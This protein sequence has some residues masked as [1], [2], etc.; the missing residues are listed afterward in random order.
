METHIQDLENYL[1]E[2]FNDLDDEGKVKARDL[3]DKNK[4]AVNEAIGKI[5][6]VVPNVK[7]DNELD[8]FLY[9]VKA[10]SN[11]A[12]KYTK[13]MIS[14]L[15]KNGNNQYSAQY[16][17]DSKNLLHSTEDLGMLYTLK[18]YFLKLNDYRDSKLMLDYYNNKISNIERKGR[19]NINN[20]QQNNTFNKKN[21][22][23]QTNNKSLINYIIANL[24]VL[25]IASFVIKVTQQKLIL[26]NCF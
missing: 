19:P 16:Y 7:E 5:K 21:I 4:E 20:S 1:A 18:D 11:R 8:E 23:S 10:K 22:S 2:K 24:C 14:E 13:D 3:V 6:G 26:S 17:E 15:N 25:L 9:K 12:V